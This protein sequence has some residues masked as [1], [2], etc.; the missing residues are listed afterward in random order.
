MIRFLTLLLLV[1]CSAFGQSVKPVESVATM[2]ELAARKPKIGEEVEVRNYSST[3]LWETPRTFRHVTN[4]SATHDGAMVSTNALASGRYVAS[5]T[6]AKAINVRWF[7]AVGNGTTDDTAAFTNAVRY[8]PVTTNDIFGIRGG[9]LLI[10][11]GTFKI[12]GVVKLPPCTVIGSGRFK[13]IIKSFV[14]ATNVFE[15]SSAQGSWPYG[16]WSYDFRGLSIIQDTNT[17]PTYGAGIR[18]TS[19]IDTPVT[20]PSMLSMHDVYVRGT[21]R[22]VWA[23]AVQGGTISHSTA[24]KCVADGFYFDTY[25]TMLGIVGS[26]AYNNGGSGWHLSGPAYCTATASGADSNTDYGWLIDSGTEQAPNANSLIVGAEGNRKAGLYIKGQHGGTISPL[27]ITPK[28]SPGAADGVVIDGGAGINISGLYFQQGTTNGTGYPLRL[29]NGPA[30]IGDN[31]AH[32]N[33][34]GGY[35]NSISPSA[36]VF[37]QVSASGNPMNWLFHEGRSRIGIGVTN[38]PGRAIDVIDRTYAAAGAGGNEMMRLES[39]TSDTNGTAF[40]TLSPDQS[41]TLY[42]LYVNSKF[43]GP[44]LYGSNADWVIRNSYSAPSSN[45]TWGS[46]RFFHGSAEVLT[47]GNNANVGSVGIGTATPNPAAALEIGY[48]N[49]GIVFPIAPYSE[50][51]NGVYFSGQYTPPAMVAWD[52]SNK[53]MLVQNRQGTTNEWKELFTVGSYWPISGYAGRP[54]GTIRGSTLDN[55]GSG[56]IRI[57][58]G[59]PSSGTDI[60]HNSIFG[61]PYRYG[62]TADTVFRNDYTGS[63]GPFGSFWFVAG[64]NKVLM[65]GNGTSRGAVAIGSTQPAASA[66]LDMQSATL[67]FLP[68]RLTSAARDAISSPATGLSIW[69]SDLSRWEV[70]NGAAWGPLA[71]GG[72]GGGPTNGSAAYVKTA[73]TSSANFTTSSEL[74]PTLTGTNITFALVANSVDTNKLA[75]NMRTFFLAR[76]NHTGT[77]AWGTLTGTPTTLSGYGITDAQTLS[78][79]LTQFATAPGAVGSIWYRAANGVVTNL[80]VGTTGTVLTV[81]NGVVLWMPAPSGGGGGGT[82]VFVDGV[83]VSNPNLL[84][85]ADITNVVTSST[86]IAPTLRTTGVTAGSYTN[87]V[88]TIDSKGRATALANGPEVM[89]GERAQFRIWDE[90]MSA[91]TS[92]GDAG[93]SGVG[94]GGSVIVTTTDPA[95]PGLK[96][97]RSTSSTAHPL[98]GWLNATTFAMT[99]ATGTSQWYFETMVKTP[100]TLSGNAGTDVYRLE[101]GFNNV[102]SGA[103]T[104]PTDGSYFSYCTNLLSAH[105]WAF[106]TRNNS[107]A[108]TV[109]DT[110]VAVTALTWYRLGVYMDATNTYGYING[111]IVATNTTQIPLGRNLAIVNRIVRTNG[112]T[113]LD[114]SIDYMSL[115]ASGFTR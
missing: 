101:S 12:S 51:T 73:F 33:Y 9:T 106:N 11:Q 17:T 75:S 47:L 42:Q 95:H 55:M 87:P 25:Q 84:T 99:N 91:S 35:L 66:T 23:S 96:G 10:P 63:S 31:S 71:T 70:Y 36:G 114:Y 108:A 72:G 53:R 112:T 13:S 49:R 38:T 50:F 97:L 82:S 90:L 83:S 58:S 76:G 80:P 109:I 86:N 104:E 7:G 15:G 89:F 21:Y 57:E 107:T 79:N 92:V 22:G 94:G 88:I 93:T 32:V 19:P 100:V 18:V 78:T 59:G 64:T 45:N 29:T 39:R 28:S 77:Q 41:T 67:G 16:I 43:G 20:G 74:D 68:P 24:D 111:N 14:S 102:V 115:K 62:T 5:D 103:T 56:V 40:V 1:G 60:E 8:L 54:L 44:Y 81:T 52:S 85:S 110:G 98:W 105:N 61:G 6:E 46:T 26:W 27:V 65:I 4:S 34:L 30:T 2:A 48:T 69:N 37:N 3:V 113:T